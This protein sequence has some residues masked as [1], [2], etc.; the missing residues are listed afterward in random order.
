[1]GLKQQ[2]T[3]DKQLLSGKPEIQVQVGLTAGLLI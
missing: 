1:M 3:K 2:P